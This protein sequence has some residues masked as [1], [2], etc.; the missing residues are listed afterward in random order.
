VVPGVFTTTQDGKGIGAITHVDG[1]Q[2]TSQNPAHPGEVVILYATGFGKVEPPVATGR[3]PTGPSKT[4][5]PVTVSI[6]GVAVTPDFAG[7]SGCCVGENQVNV[8]IPSG[9]RSADNI[10]VVLSIGGAQ[11]NPVTISVRP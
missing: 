8:K 6:D 4:V 5:A 9:T 2:I 3:L 7:L 11:S 10:A 1:S